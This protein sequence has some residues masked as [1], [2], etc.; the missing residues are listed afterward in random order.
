MNSGCSDPGKGSP[1]EMWPC[2]PARTLS[3]PLYPTCGP[4]KGLARPRGWVDWKRKPEPTRGEAA[5]LGSRALESQGREDRLI[6]LWLW[7]LLVGSKSPA[8]SGQSEA[9][10]PATAA[11]RAPLMSKALGT[12]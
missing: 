4:S 5:D 9:L 7:P 3:S 1:A 2:P 12:C 11:R 6:E 10:L 8:S